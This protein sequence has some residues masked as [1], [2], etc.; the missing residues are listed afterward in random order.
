MKNVL[1][2]VVVSGSVLLSGSEVRAD[3]SGWFG[4]LAERVEGGMNRLENPDG[5]N[6]EIDN[7]TAKPIKIATSGDGENKLDRC[8]N[9]ASDMCNSIDSM[10]IAPGEKETILIRAKATPPADGF[11]F[12][13][14]VRSGAL[15]SRCSIPAAKKG[16]TYRFLVDNSGPLGKI[17]CTPA[18]RGR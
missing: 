17:N 18:V 6:L 4:R 3:L 1:L 7:Q 14:T 15:F 8:R 16:G 5:I 11:K 10:T 2:G 9:L 13:A 12:T